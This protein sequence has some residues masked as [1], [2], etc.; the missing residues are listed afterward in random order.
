MTLLAAAYLAR[1]GLRV[2]VLGQGTPEPTYRLEGFELPRTPAFPLPLGSPGLRHLL[3]AVAVMPALKR[4]ASAPSIPLPLRL[5]G[6][7]LDLARDD[8]LRARAIEREFPRARG[9]MARFE[10]RAHLAREAFDHYV[11][12]G[13][14]FHGRGF[15][16]SRALSRFEK[17]PVFA[18]DVVG[19][20]PLDELRSEPRLVDAISFHA[21]MG[22]NHARPPAGLPLALAYDRTLD[23]HAHLDGGEHWL[24][25]SIIERIESYGGDVRLRVSA[26]RVLVQGRSVD[27][28]R[29]RST[30]DEVGASAIISGI[31]ASSLSAL[32]SE[33]STA[34]ESIELLKTSAPSL[35]RHVSN[36]AFATEGIPRGL[37][38]ELYVMPSRSDSRLVGCRLERTAED[39]RLAWISVVSLVSWPLED[40]AALRARVLDAIREVIPFADR[41]LR[42]F[43]SP[44]DELGVRRASAPLDVDDDAPPGIAVETLEDLPR[45]EPAGLVG[46]PTVLPLEGLY[47][48][49]GQCFPELGVEGEI[50][51]SL[52]VCRRLLKKSG[53]ARFSRLAPFRSRRW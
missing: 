50:L 15:R 53:S 47:L 43:H 1:N 41:H 37:G 22:S 49:N 44:N 28:L 46:L 24:R 23:G 38:R 48:S 12:S 30:M 4:R 29:L 6:K 34:A 21:R 16:A 7:S 36:L 42:Y 2:L 9:P 25:Q 39:A 13:G 11:Q 52:D 10:R 8:K 31:P 3:E 27:G 14:T 26:N 20:D 17:H 5:P 35:A 40:P 18:G 19:F 51:A 45:R 33:S 32:L